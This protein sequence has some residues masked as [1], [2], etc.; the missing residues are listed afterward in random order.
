M[1][2]K[3][4]DLRRICS[5]EF[6]VATPQQLASVEFLFGLFT[7]QEFTDEFAT[8]VTGTSNSHQRVKPDDLSRMTAVIPR[9]ECVKKYSEN[10]APMLQ[11][12][13]QNLDNSEILSS[14]RDT[15]LPRLLSGEL[16]VKQ[17]ERIVAEANV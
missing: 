14:L 3:R 4:S 13:Y 7:S 2:H 8:L 5:T 1:P 6:I 10:V 9:P 17:A 15:L 16:G 12:C 11:R